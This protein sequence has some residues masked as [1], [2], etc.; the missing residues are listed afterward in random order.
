MMSKVWLALGKLVFLLLLTIVLGYGVAA[1]R[2]AQFGNE[3]SDESAD[4]AVVL[5]AAAW[6]D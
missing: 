6:G 4:A 2:V 3:R 1:L 5:G